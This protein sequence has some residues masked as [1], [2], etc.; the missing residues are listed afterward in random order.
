MEGHA[1]GEWGQEAHCN[2]T[3]SM[4]HF[5]KAEYHRDETYNHE[6]DCSKDSAPV[7]LANGQ[8][9]HD[10]ILT[11]NFYFVN[12]ASK[13]DLILQLKSQLDLDIFWRV[14]FHRLI[15]RVLLIRL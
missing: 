10:V 15:N 9:C 13:L 5:F 6:A 3:D 14:T 12:Q 11:L 1:C 7:L 8:I 4:A 2:Y